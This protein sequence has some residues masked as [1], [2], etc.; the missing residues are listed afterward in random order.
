MFYIL[1]FS[2]F[3]SSLVSKKHHSPESYNHGLEFFHFFVL[4]MLTRFATHRQHVVSLEL[5]DLACLVYMVQ[6]VSVT[7]KLR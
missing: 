6:T 2:C 7:L 3:M 5:N 4:Y 1:M